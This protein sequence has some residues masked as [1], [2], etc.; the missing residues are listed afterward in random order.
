M[1]SMYTCSSD[2]HT[3]LLYELLYG[4]VRIVHVREDR[5]YTRECFIA[6]T[7]LPHTARQTDCETSNQLRMQQQDS[8]LP[9]AD[10][11]PRY[12]LPSV[13]QAWTFN[14]HIVVMIRVV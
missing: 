6:W 13:S 7:L 1:V 9:Q 12:S 4:L 8:A 10:S 5:P 2:E 3:A 14:V 11:A